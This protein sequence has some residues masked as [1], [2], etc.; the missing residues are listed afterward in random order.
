MNLF[1]KFMIEWENF[2]NLGNS[3]RL[4]DG[5]KYIIGQLRRWPYLYI[6]GQV[7]YEGDGFMDK[8]FESFYKVWNC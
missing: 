5:F 1:H 2:I 3:N 8:S 6:G 7:K 4:I